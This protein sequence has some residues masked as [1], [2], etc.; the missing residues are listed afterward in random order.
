MT[1]L[2][3]TRTTTAHCVKPVTTEAVKRVAGAET[4]NTAGVSNDGAGL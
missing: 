4:E 2:Q 1:L 3:T